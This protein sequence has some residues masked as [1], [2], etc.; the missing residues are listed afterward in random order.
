MKTQLLEDIGQ[1]AGLP[2]APAKAVE[3]A[4]AGTPAQGPATPR[5]AQPVSPRSA[6]GVWRQKP[7]EEAPAF[8]TP[9]LVEEPAPLALDQVFEEIAALEAQL[10]HPAQQQAPAIAQVAPEPDVPAALAEPLIARADQPAEDS[11]APNPAYI[12]TAPPAPLFDFTQPLPTPQ[13]ANPFTPAPSGFTRSRK[14]YL[15]GAA[16]VLS[17]ALLAWGGH[18]LYQERSDA[19]SM[20][21]IA[22]QRPVDT[23]VNGQ[24]LAKKA[25]MPEPAAEA[26]A[27]VSSPIPPLVMLEPDDPPAVVKPEQAVRPRVQKP[28]RT[29]ERET[30]SPPPKPSVRKVRE[31]SRAAVR[32]AKE[33][34]R[35]EPV[36][37]LARAAA[38]PVERPAAP[39]TSM[40][41]LLRACRE[42][43][44][45]ATQCIKRECSVTAYGFAC[46]GR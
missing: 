20:A 2:L 40:A 12:A 37:Q 6:T 7:A 28:E 43:G 34:P 1:S 31:P 29:L 22:A 46:R 44:Y 41:A 32:P 38:I 39:D 30:A 35:R 15:L 3:L 18:W 19:G 45:H 17:A 26:T 9:Q 23:P 8:T 10:V 25:A 27:P 13:E 42:H 36:R 33:L 21:L 5:K 16:C 11:T 4:Q 24:A 14:R